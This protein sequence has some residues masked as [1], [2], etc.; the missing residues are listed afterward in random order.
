MLNYIWLA[1]I[2]LGVGAALTTDIINSS[3]NRYKNDTPLNITISFKDNI[4]VLKEGKHSAQIKVDASTFNNFYNDRSSSDL[5]ADAVI[6]F[7]KDFKFAV[8]F[9]YINYF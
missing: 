7:N 8:C 6:N 5:E 1:L 2:L 3:T 4:D 9:F